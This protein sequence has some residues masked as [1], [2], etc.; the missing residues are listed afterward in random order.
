MAGLW[1]FLRG[2]VS[3]FIYTH[4]VPRISLHVVLSVELVRSTIE[5]PE[6]R[7]ESQSVAVDCIRYR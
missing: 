2:W 4:L 3:C 6:Y 7:A 5:G 1:Q